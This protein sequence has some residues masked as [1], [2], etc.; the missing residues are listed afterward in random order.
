MRSLRAIFFDIDDTLFSTSVFAEKA[1]RNAMEAMIRYGL[2]VDRDALVRELEEVISEFSSNYEHHFDKLLLRVP[3]KSFE[4][5]NRAILVAA[6]VVAYHETK[7]HE[8]KVF[9]DAYELLRD[10]SKTPV[11]MGIISA[12]LSIKQAE[13]IVRLN[14]YEFLNPEAIFI[15]EQVGI[16]KPNPKLYQRACEQLGVP[17]EQVMYIGD[18]PANDIAPPKKLGM[19]TVL[20]RRSGKYAKD[21]V[22]VEPDYCIGHFHELRVIL[23]QDFG[24][25]LGQHPAPHPTTEI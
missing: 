14:I 16:S 13:K 24:I 10:L 17:P 8:L 12:G 11:I 19:V 23:E 20:H 6:G 5:I 9:D 21:P 1:R 2:K 4:G 15:S 7:F 25:D 18:H 3:Q 22:T